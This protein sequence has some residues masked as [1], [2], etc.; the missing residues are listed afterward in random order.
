MG[1]ITHGVPPFSVPKEFSHFKD[2]ISS[3]MLIAGVAILGISYFSK[4]SCDY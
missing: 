3:A 2:L 1:N 4:V